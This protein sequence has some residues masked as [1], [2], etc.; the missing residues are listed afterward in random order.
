[1]PLFVA[2]ISELK[3]YRKK[4]VAMGDRARTK[5]LRRVHSFVGPE[6]TLRTKRRMNAGVD[7]DGLPLKSRR[8]ARRGTPPL[9]GAYKAYGRSLKWSLDTNGDLKHFSTHPG[10]DV[11]YS[12]KDIVP[13]NGKFLT[14]PVEAPG[15]FANDSSSPADDLSLIGNRSGL[16]A[17]HYKNTFFRW[18]TGRLWLLQKEDNSKRLR[19]L[20]LLVKKTSRPPNKWMGFSTKPVLASSSDVD[21]IRDA[22]A[23]WVIGAA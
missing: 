8:A 10:A 1:M 16:R 19:F 13:V 11:V 12:G 7:V 3:T 2:D 9:G 21:M 20:F 18:L 23:R 5:N 17:R 22:Y 14:L 6:I 15:G 4:L